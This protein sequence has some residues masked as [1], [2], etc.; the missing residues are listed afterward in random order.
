M[1]WLQFIVTLVVALIVF[2]TSG[3]WVYYAGADEKK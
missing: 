3:R 2:G 1:A